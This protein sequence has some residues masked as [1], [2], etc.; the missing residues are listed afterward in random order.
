L[1]VQAKS[2]LSLHPLKPSITALREGLFFREAYPAI[3]DEE[4]ELWRA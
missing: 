3:S 2:G 4:L 1:T